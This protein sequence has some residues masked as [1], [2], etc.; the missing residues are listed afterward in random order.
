[1]EDDPQV[2]AASCD[3]RAI[4][5][6]YRGNTPVKYTAPEPE[7]SCCPSGGE[8]DYLGKSAPNSW[9]W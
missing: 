8:P 1:M 6:R 3:S 2:P 7:E 9:N 4:V 5:V